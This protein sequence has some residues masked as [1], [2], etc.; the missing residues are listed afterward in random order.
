MKNELDCIRGE[1]NSEIDRLKRDLQD[2]HDSLLDISKSKGAEVQ[3]MLSRF[4][5]EKAELESLNKVNFNPE[6]VFRACF[7]LSHNN[8]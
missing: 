7:F 5:H 1:Q 4:N 8:K 6:K 2:A 3:G